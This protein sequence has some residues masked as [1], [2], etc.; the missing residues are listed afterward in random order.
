MKGSFLLV[1]TQLS[2]E[3]RDHRAQALFQTHREHQL[4]H[5]YPINCIVNPSLQEWIDC[6]T[7]PPSIPRSLY[8]LLPFSK[9]LY[10]WTYNTFVDVT[11]FDIAE[12]G[13]E[14]LLYWHLS[15]ATTVNNAPANSILLWTKDEYFWFID[16]TP[17]QEEFKSRILGGERL[18][19]L[20]R[21]CLDYTQIELSF[22]ELHL[23]THKGGHRI[24]ITEGK[25]LTYKWST[26]GWTTTLENPDHNLV[27]PQ[28]YHFPPE[29]P[30]D[31][32]VIELL[33]F[34]EA[35]NRPDPGPNPPISPL[36][37]SSPPTSPSNSNT[38]GWGEPNPLWGL[39]TCWCNKE[40]CDCGNCPQTP[41]TPPSVVLWS[42]GQKYLPYHA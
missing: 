5:F 40:V 21:F 30:T 3:E 23:L 33:E 28:V 25:E 14:Q 17:H 37:P 35:R 6:W 41:P 7:D 39:N 2:D 22:Q 16:I 1:S 32:E 4:R 38:D 42:P 20:E 12:Q 24:V 19:Y 15:Q 13:S 18:R 34:R 8:T 31:P 27:D 29:T 10:P 11:L 36:P 26:P 9:I